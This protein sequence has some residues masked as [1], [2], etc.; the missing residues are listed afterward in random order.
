MDNSELS[1]DS[2]FPDTGDT[3]TSPITYK[4]ESFEL[5]PPIHGFTS[6]PLR[7][8]SKH[9]L[10]GDHLW[11]GA[12]WSARYI[13]DHPE[14]VHNLE[15]DKSKSVLE[16]GAG[17]G[18]PSLICALLGANVVVTD[19]PDHELI[20]N[21]EYNIDK[22]RNLV[23]ANQKKV[24]LNIT[25][26]GYLWGSSIEHLISAYG[27]FDIIILSDVVFNHS[28]HDKLLWSCKQCLKEGGLVIC[29]FTHYRPHL[30]HKDLEFLEKAQIVQ[31]ND[32]WVFRVEKVDE[33]KMPDV[34]FPL[35]RGDADVRRTVHAYFM[36]KER[37][38]LT[39]T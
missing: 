31:E 25:A 39:S 27:L 16:L 9:V 18:L 35:D 11:N 30:A 8:V 12:L 34:M 5:S 4:Y 13:L 3:P 21:L 38:S 37:T 15:G 7:M 33:I 22:L 26:K 6:I 23:D 28:E 2:F 17:A 1:L 36:Y 29:V 10:W 14:I 19:Y 32:E 24:N 20:S